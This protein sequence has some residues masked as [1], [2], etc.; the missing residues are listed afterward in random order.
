MTDSHRPHDD[1]SAAGY[2]GRGGSVFIAKQLSRKEWQN[3]PE[4]TA[5]VLDEWNKLIK[6][7]CWDYDSV[8]EY[9]SVRGRAIDKKQTVHFG[10]LFELCH[11]K[12]S[13]LD[14]KHWKYKGR[15]VFAGNNV[16]DE[17]SNVA[18][19]QDLQSS[20]SLMSASKFLEFI[21]M[22][23]GNSV[24]QELRNKHTPKPCC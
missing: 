8:A 15:V 18:I 17:H 7:K 21:G 20:A 1:V 11:I 12:H 5:S 13:E 22:T 24:Q 14:K 2:L 3:I 10:R 23:R 19:F 9:Q 6:L 16:T 4:A